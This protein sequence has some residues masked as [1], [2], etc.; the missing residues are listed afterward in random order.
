MCV[1]G[2]Q[3]YIHLA[4]RRINLKIIGNFYQILH[5]FK[6]HPSCVCVCGSETKVDKNAQ[7]MFIL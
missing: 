4:L 1:K 2:I 3:N 7:N 5:T 6:V